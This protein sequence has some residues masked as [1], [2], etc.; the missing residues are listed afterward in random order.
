MEEKATESSIF[1]ELDDENISRGFIE[2]ENPSPLAFSLLLDYVYGIYVVDV[3][4]KGFG[5]ARDFASVNRGRR[6]NE[7]VIRILL[8]LLELDIMLQNAFFSLLVGLDLTGAP[9]KTSSRTRASSFFSF[10]FF[11][12]GLHGHRV[13]MM[14]GFANLLGDRRSP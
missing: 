11:V 2:S 9:S 8:G 12:H 1:Q 13:S 6:S 14:T 4:I 3:S 7:R 5:L 10:F